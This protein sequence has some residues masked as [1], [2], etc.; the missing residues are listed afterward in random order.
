MDDPGTG[1]AV[2]TA[3]N[4][5]MEPGR[6]GYVVPDGALLALLALDGLLLGA[7]GLVF[8]PLY[9][10][11]VPV[12]MG[13]VLS[14]LVLPW[15]VHRAGEVNTRP[16]VAAVPLVA[17]VVAVGVLGL[18]GPGGDAMLALDWQSLLLLA[19]GIGAGLWALRAVL[20]EYYRRERG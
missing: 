12:P 8:T 4:D 10:K 11:G 5:V 17:W 14:I 6:P 20:E 16:A 9:T 2:S 1:P 19:G 3:T 18:F 15:L 13:A 7:F